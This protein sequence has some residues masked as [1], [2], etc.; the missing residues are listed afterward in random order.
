[1]GDVLMLV[2]QNSMLSR[3]PREWLQRG[4]D[5]V[6]HDCALQRLP[7]RLPMDRAGLVG[8]DGPTHCGIFDIAYLAC[9]PIIVVAASSDEAELAHMVATAAAFDEY[10]F[11]F[12]YPRG[13]GLGVD[14]TAAGVG[15][16]FKGIPIDIGK[17]RIMQ[18]GE[19]V[20][21]LGYGSGTNFAMQAASLLQEHGFSVTVADGRFC[22]P[23]DTALISKLA[24]THK[25]LLTVEEG[26][27]GGYGSH[28]M[29]YLA[30]SGLLDGDLIF[31]PVCL[32]D[33]FIDHGNPADQL[34]AGKLTGA[35]I[36]ATV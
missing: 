5:Q 31:R 20:A 36:A 6:I 13:S 15:S 33:K 23:L 12:R 1:M 16:D 21:L 28:V 4:Y 11:A 26:S 14:L 29:Q 27:I 18:E 3:L 7:V 8:A 2:S 19:E 10:P 30:L 9:V 34:K 32:P 22:K 17:G 25:I 24:K 35:D